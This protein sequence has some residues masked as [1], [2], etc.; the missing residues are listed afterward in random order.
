MFEIRY[1]NPRKYIFMEANFLIIIKVGLNLLIYHTGRIFLIYE[2]K[3]RNN[4]NS[5]FLQMKKDFI[6]KI[7]IDLMV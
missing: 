6:D 4:I 3:C 1:D 2:R 7:R 5:G